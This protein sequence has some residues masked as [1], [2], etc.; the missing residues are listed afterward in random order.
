MGQIGLG[1][2]HLSVEGV[3]LLS[4]CREELVEGGRVARGL[5]RV[6][7]EVLFRARAVFRQFEETD[8]TLE[9]GGPTSR[10]R[11]NDFVSGGLRKE[12][13]FF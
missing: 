8:E 10:Q 6:K 11:E 9:E 7:E 2:G 13:D 12:Y 3:R 1:V 4:G 5:L